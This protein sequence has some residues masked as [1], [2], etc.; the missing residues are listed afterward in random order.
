MTTIEKACD[1][2]LNGKQLALGETPDGAKLTLLEA[3]VMA[4]LIKYSFTLLAWNKRFR[5]IADLEFESGAEAY[6][7]AKAIKRKGYHGLIQQIVRKKAE[8]GFMAY[9]A[10]LLKDWSF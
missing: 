6:Q 2:D 5:P 3:S 8:N 4:G 1:A 7:V 10:T 9:H